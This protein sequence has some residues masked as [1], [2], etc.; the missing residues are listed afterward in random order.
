V[1]KPVAPSASCKTATSQYNLALQKWDD[2]Q[3]PP[4]DG[5]GPMH[6]TEFYNMFSA[7]QNYKK[8][9][10]SFP[11]VNNNVTSP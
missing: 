11:P 2:A 7:I 1:V 3:P 4:G 5:E 10:G 9:C 6:G 8:A